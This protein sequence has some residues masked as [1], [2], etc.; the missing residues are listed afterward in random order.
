M[1]ELVGGALRAL[2]SET[3]A[4][5]CALDGAD[6]TEYLWRGDPALWA[7]HAPVLFPH[8][9]R[10]PGGCYTWR[11][12]TYSLPLHGFAGE[13]VFTVEARTPASVALTLRDDAATRAQYPFAFL[14]RVEYALAGETLRACFTV[15][16]QGDGPM[17]FGLGAH[18]GFCVP[19]REGLALDDYA[20][21]FGAPCRPL[22]HLLGDDCLMSGETAPFSV[23]EGVTLRL[24]SDL[25]D[26][27]AL[28]LSEMA[29]SVTLFTAYD[30]RTVEVT[31][32]DAPYLALWQPPHTGCAVFV[33]RALAFASR[34]GRRRGRMVGAAHACAAFAR[35]AAAVSLVGRGG[36]AGEAALRRH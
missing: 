4:E 29:R 11:G 12:E 2:V 33:H 14:L 35:G 1:I 19:L 13:R 10:L 30:W 18:P 31:F 24:S 16:N 23:R 9:G 20:L 8:V 7:R 36:A 27:D 3:G 6:G 25:F 22:Q 5:L 15:E 34:A 32:P 26:R 28:V 21:R 17:P